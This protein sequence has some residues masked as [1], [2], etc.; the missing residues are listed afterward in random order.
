MGTNSLFNADEADIEQGLYLGASS[1]PGLG[2]PGQPH[3][4]QGGWRNTSIRQPQSHPRSPQTH[5]SVQSCF[6]PSPG[7]RSELWPWFYANTL[8]FPPHTHL[9]FPSAEVLPT[10]CTYSAFMHELKVLKYTDRAAFL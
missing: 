2:Q 9:H 7:A 5:E 10:K 4:A 3:Q 6:S 1:I 8:A